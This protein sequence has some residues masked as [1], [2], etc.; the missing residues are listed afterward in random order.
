MAL[1]SPQEVGVSGA[2]HRLGEPIES[3]RASWLPWAWVF[4]GPAGSEETATVSQHAD[5]RIKTGGESGLAQTQP[6]TRLPDIRR[7]GRD[8]REDGG[9]Q[10]S[11]D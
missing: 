5:L 11:E 9:E 7:G 3:L 10:V 2:D 8:E 6:G 4:L 1:A